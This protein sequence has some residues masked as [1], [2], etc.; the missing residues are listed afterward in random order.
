[1]ST[2]AKL[3]LLLGT[4]VLVVA[5]AT[6]RTPSSSGQLQAQSQATAV[7]LAPDEKIALINVKGKFSDCAAAV[8]QKANPSLRVVHER[9][10]R[11]SVFPWFEPDIAPDTDDELAALLQ[12]P[13]VSNRVAQLGVRYVVV[14]SGVTTT[15]PVTDLGVPADAAQRSVCSS[16]ARLNKALSQEE[17]PAT[18]S[19]APLGGASWDEHTSLSVRVWDLRAAQSAGSI[20]A[21]ASGHGAVGIFVVVPF[22]FVPDTADTVCDDIGWRLAQFFSGGTLVKPK[23]L[24]N[25][26][27]AQP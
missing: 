24:R 11:D 23:P 17:N 16:Q 25:P 5:C 2:F 18:L 22:A 12:R 3:G 27:P 21:H 19:Q 6:G 20:A 8:M 13:V 15:G 7:D 9:E 26:N 1:M 10:F 14:V 4:M